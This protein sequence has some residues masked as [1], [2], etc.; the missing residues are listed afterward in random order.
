MTKEE[1][2]EQLRLGPGINEDVSEEYNDAVD[3]AIKALEQQ[4]IEDCVRRQAVIEI[5]NKSDACLYEKSDNNGL[6]EE[7]KTLPL[8]TPTFPE[9]A[10]NGDMIRAIFPSASETDH[11]NSPIGNIIYI[12]LEEYQEMRVQQDWW[13]APYK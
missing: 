3:M 11:F 9:G 8:V 6:V 4:P 5:I 12:R 7:I 2:L 13:N 1:A 10:T